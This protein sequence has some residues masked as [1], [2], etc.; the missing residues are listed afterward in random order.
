VF[1]VAPVGK[2]KKK[3]KKKKKHEEEQQHWRVFRIQEGSGHIHNGK[4]D[5][6]GRK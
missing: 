5:E 2:K 1:L 4:Q 3:K 6:E